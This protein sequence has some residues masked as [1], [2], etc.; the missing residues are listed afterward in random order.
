[1][2]KKKKGKQ[3]SAAG[4]DLGDDGSLPSPSPSP[5]PTAVPPTQQG[6]SAQAGKKSS[7]APK[8]AS[9]APSSSS[10]LIICRNKHWRHISS[11]HGAWLQ[12]PIEILE[13][14][15]NINYN[16]P[17]PRPVDPAVLFD[18][19][20][21]RKNVDEASDLAVRAASDIASSTLSSVSGGLPSLSSMNS[22]GLGS[23]GHGVKLSRERRF[24]MRELG[25]QKLA[26]AYRL[27]EIACSVAAMQGASTLEDIAGLVLQRNPTD[28]DAKYVHFFHEKIPSRQL[29]ESTSLQPLK[30]IMSVRTGQPE[31]L[32]TLA[33]VKVFKDDL[34]GAAQD[35]S[36]AIALSRFRGES[37][38]P[39]ADNMQVQQAQGSRRR[40]LDVILSEDDQPSGL[41]SQLLF[42]RGCVYLSMASLCVPDGIPYPSAAEEE[43]EENAANGGSGEHSNGG[44]KQHPRNAPEVLAAQADSRKFVKTTAKR[45]LRDFMAFISQFEYTSDLP[46]KLNKEF[47]ERVLL[48]SQGM[49]NPR[50]SDAN[51]PT[52]PHTVHALAD[53]FAAVPPSNLPEFP[54]RDVIKP[55]VAASHPSTTCEWVTFH[56]LLTEALHCLLLCHCLAQTSA[57]EVQRHAYMVAR[58]ARLCDGYPVFQASRSP[59]RTDWVE[60]LRRTKNWVDLGSG[61]EKLCFPAPLPLYDPAHH[62]ASAV[63]NPARASA[64]AALVN[65]S[66]ATVQGQGKRRVA[67]LKQATVEHEH[68]E[69]ASIMEDKAA[70]DAAIAAMKK[71][72]KRG[73]DMLSTDALGGT[74]FPPAPVPANMDPSLFWGSEDGLPEASVRSVCIAQWVLRAPIVTG[75]KRKKRVKKGGSSAKVDEAAEDV[76]K[77]RL[78]ERVFGDNA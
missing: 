73:G 35:L 28:P 70:I 46:V 5:M 34:E 40:P 61:W 24:R 2:A 60:V 66:A 51:S 59:A 54:T 72:V 55:G 69:Y 19:I 1:M 74:G 22:Y 32:R 41:E 30:D 42:Q 16:T 75:T 62:P 57:K 14:I 37:H 11:F 53:L 26:R 13:T 7:K 10:S 44:A 48:A 29:A 31:V 18:I 56:P 63:P 12:M 17:R 52:E 76:G 21:I 8:E 50:C 27:D 49:R 38:R 6:S 9:L 39:A 3:P 43:A 77:M 58:L 68:D 25:S 78:E 64:A 67:R 4:D 36:D 33:T 15:A 20:K 45:A 23:G 65:S 47:N 71:G